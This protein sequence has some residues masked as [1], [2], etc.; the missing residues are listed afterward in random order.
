M[1]MGATYSTGVDRNNITR[2]FAE[3]LEFSIDYTKPLTA[4]RV[5]NLPKIGALIQLPGMTKQKITNQIT[6]SNGRSYAFIYST[7]SVPQIVVASTG[8]KIFRN[9]PR[10]QQCCDLP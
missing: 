4:N 3:Y 1:S 10:R 5:G 9:K 8:L 7:I 6:L 2:V